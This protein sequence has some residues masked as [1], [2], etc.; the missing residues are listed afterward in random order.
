MS[1]RKLHFS[2]IAER[3]KRCANLK[4]YTANITQ[5]LR[6]Y[7]R[8][9]TEKNSANQAGHCR[10]MVSSLMHRTQVAYTTTAAKNSHPCVRVAVGTNRGGASGNAAVALNS[11]NT[12]AAHLSRRRASRTHMVEYWGPPLPSGTV[13]LMYSCGVLIEQHLQCTQFCALICNF[14]LPCSS[15]TYS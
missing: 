5:G 6:P 3:A 14:G 1:L 10:N 12:H 15:G 11:A 2:S 7:K 4:I 9:G 13:Q 8:R